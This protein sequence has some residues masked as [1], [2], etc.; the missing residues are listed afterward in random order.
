MQ[1]ILFPEMSH[2]VVRPQY[3]DVVEGHAFFVLSAPPVL[4][5][6]VSH[7]CET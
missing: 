3:D 2:H 6:V 1:E 4:K 7:L 5:V